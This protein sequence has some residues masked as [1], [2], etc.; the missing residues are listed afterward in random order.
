MVLL[1]F[2]SAEADTSCEGDNKCLKPK[3]NLKLA[4]PRYY[5]DS[6]LPK[7]IRGAKGRASALNLNYLRIQYYYDVKLGSNFTCYHNHLLRHVVSQLSVTYVTL[8]MMDLDL[9]KG[10]NRELLTQTLE[11]RRE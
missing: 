6:H 3:L 8:H 7:Q 10:R 9:C 1:R 11:W 5:Y 2:A 4:L